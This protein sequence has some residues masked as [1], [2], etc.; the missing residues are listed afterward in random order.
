MKDE[1]PRCE[2]RNKRAWRKGHFN[3]LS[4]GLRSEDATSFHGRNPRAIRL[5]SVE[6]AGESL[7]FQADNFAVR[8]PLFLHDLE[9]PAPAAQGRERSG[10]VDAEVVSNRYFDE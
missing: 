6:A 3:V 8:A 1:D 7:N 10:D 9:V 5:E 4:S 2:S